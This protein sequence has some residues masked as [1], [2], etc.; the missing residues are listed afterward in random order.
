MSIFNYPQDNTFGG[1]TEK[2]GLTSDGI[3]GADTERG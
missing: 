3:V 1:D 2:T